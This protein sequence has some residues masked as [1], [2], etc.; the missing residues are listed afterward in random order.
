MDYPVKSAAEF[1]TLHAGDKIKAT[2]NV[3]AAGDDYNVSNIQKQNP[4][5]K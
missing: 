3:N 5:S 1:K 4:G 2:L